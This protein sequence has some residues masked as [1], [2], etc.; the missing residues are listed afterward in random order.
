MRDDDKLVRQLSLVAFLM[1]QQRPVTADEIHEA[2]EGYG[3]MSEQAFL[4]RFYSDRAEIESLG[5]RLAV[6]RPSDDPFQGDLYALPAENFYL[7]PTRL[8]RGR[9]V[10]PA[11][12]PVPAGGAV[13]LRR[14]AAPGAA[15]PDP[16]TAE[17]A[18]RPRRAHGV[19]Q[20]ARPATTRPR[21][22]RT[23]PRSSRRSAAARRSASPTSRSGATS[24]R[25]ARSTPTAC[26]TPAGTG[27]WSASRTSA[28]R[29][30][31]SA[32]RASRGASR[33]R[34]APSTISARRRTSTSRRTA[35]GRRGSSTSRSAPPSSRSRPTIGWWVEQMFGTQGTHRAPGRRVRH[36]HARTTATS[37][38]S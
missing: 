11:D 10:G 4:R 21:W 1:S 37:A 20:P 2:V 19:G 18:G 17:P 31:S 27:T 32:S 15:E 22:R 8:R 12:L 34:R 23:W 16:R 28:T 9:A 26:S 7:P 24:A 29:R 33:S 30:A 25:S 35:T 14:A 13:R 6:E 5:L 38:S 36:L 3:G